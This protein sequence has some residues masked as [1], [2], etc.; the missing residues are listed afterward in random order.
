MEELI[1]FIEGF[2]IGFRM[3]LLSLQG[4]VWKL[5]VMVVPVQGIRRTGVGDFWNLGD[6]EEARQDQDE[7]GNGEVDPLHVGERCVIVKIVEEHI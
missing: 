7:D 3:C 5:L 2:I 4:H 6:V 1:L